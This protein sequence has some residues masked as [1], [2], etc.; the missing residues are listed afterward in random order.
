MELIEEEVS[1]GR[2]DNCTGCSTYKPIGKVGIV[3]HFL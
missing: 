3:P 2:S 1:R